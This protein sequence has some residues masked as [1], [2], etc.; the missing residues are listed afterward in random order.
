MF[1]VL[2]GVFKF[3]CLFFQ[4]RGIHKSREK[5]WRDR[6]ING[7]GVEDVKFTKN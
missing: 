2:F 3:V 7:T 1:V 4:L 5:I 6:E